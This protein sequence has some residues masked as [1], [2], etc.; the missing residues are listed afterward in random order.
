MTTLILASMFAVKFAGG[1]PNEFITALSLDT[2][3][4]VMMTQGDGHVISRAEFATGDLNEMAR[5][6][7]TQLNHA[8]LPGT[9]LILSD[10]LVA[11]EKVTQMRIQRARGSGEGVDEVAMLQAIEA[12]RNSQS[13]QAAG[14]FEP[15]L[16]PLPKTAVEDGKVTFKTEGR[17]ALQ[18][19]MTRQAISRPVKV[20]WFYD[21][22]PIFVHVKDQPEEEFMRWLAKAVGARLVVNAKEYAFELNPVEVRRRAVA[23]IQK[24]P[25]PQRNSE[26]E[27]RERNFR[28][29]CLNALSPVQVSAALAESGSSTRIELGP[30]SPLT[31]LAVQRVQQID[32]ERQAR[33]GPPGRTQPTIMQRV[34]PSRTAILIVDARLSVS[35]EI[36]VLDQNGRP[37][38]VVRL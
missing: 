25:L 19:A 31:R 21:R 13:G 6:I 32:A 2:Q 33:P 23:T 7:R 16:I 18:I 36:P 8:I 11:R 34:D 4:N 26:N 12:T 24:E 15:N 17:D 20:H 10:E 29:A 9:E 27:T 1:T 30:R 3:Q 35:M 5:A 28:I 37:A 38:G 14:R 22:S